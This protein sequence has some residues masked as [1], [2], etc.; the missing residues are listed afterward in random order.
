MQIRKNRVLKYVI[1]VLIFCIV[2]TIGNVFGQEILMK[3]NK[4]D[5][6]PPSPNSTALAKMI[7]IP[8]EE[9]TGTV[10]IDLPLYTIKNKEYEMPISL[11]Y[12]TNGIHVE[13]IS[14]WV[15]LGWSLN[16][17]GLVTRAVKGLPDDKYSTDDDD[18]GQGYLDSFNLFYVGENQK[19]ED[20]IFLLDQFGRGFYDSEPDMFYFKVPGYSGKF[21]F[22]NSEKIH[23]IPKQNIVIECQ[24]DAKKPIESF[25]LITP[26]GNK[27]FFKD[28]ESTVH[29]RSNKTTIFNSTW[30][31]SKVVT[32]D[33]E[34]S[35]KYVDEDYLERKISGEIARYDDGE[36]S[37]FFYGYSKGIRIHAKRLQEISWKDG[38]IVFDADHLRRD[39]TI[40]E[41]D[42]NNAYALSKIRIQNNEGKMV[43][44]YSFDYEYFDS[45]ADISENT[46]LY[47]RLKLVSFSQFDRNNKKH[48]PYKF[49][50]NDYE[51]PARVSLERDFWGFYNNNKAKSLI[52]NLYFYPDGTS[53]VYESQYSIFARSDMSNKEFFLE[54]N[55]DRNVNEVA[56]KA[57]VLEKMIYPTGGNVKIHYTPN[58]FIFNDRV[59]LGGG[60]R[61]SK[62]EYSMN[63]KVKKTK[64]YLYNENNSKCSEGLLFRI[65]HFAFQRPYLRSSKVDLE[66]LKE[67]TFYFSKSISELDAY[68]GNMV[69]YEYVTIKESENG[70]V[71]KKFDIPDI[72]KDKVLLKN[73]GTSHFEIPRYHSDTFGAAY[74]E[75]ENPTTKIGGMYRHFRFALGVYDNYPFAPLPDL[76]SYIGNLVEEHYYQQDNDK[77]PVKSIEYQYE[78]DDTNYINQAVVAFYEA[79]IYVTISHFDFT[80]TTRGIIHDYIRGRY[81]NLSGVKRLISKKEI[82]YS[83]LKNGKSIQKNVTYKY[84]SKNQLSCKI[85]QSSEGKELK[86]SY[87]YPVDYYFPPSKNIRQSCDVVSDVFRQMVENNMLEYPI[88]I[89]SYKD[90]KIIG[91]DLSLYKRIPGGKIKPSTHNKIELSSP[92]KPNIFGLSYVNASLD[93]LN[94]S[95]I[96]FTK[97][98]YY[99]KEIIYEKYDS[100]GNLVQYRKKDGIPVSLLW[101]SSGN[102]LIAKVEGCLYTQ[103]SFLNGMSYSSCKVLYDNIQAVVPK[104]KISTY[105]YEKLIGLSSQTDPNGITTY[106]EYDDFGR[107]KFVKDHESNITEK[108]NYNYALDKFKCSS[109]TSDISNYSL[110]N[111]ANF[112]ITPTGGSGDYSY[113][114]SFINGHSTLQ[115][116]TM[117]SFRVL[118]NTH[119]EM[120][121][122]CVVTDK[123]TGES[124]EKEILIR[125]KDYLVKFTNITQSSDGIH[126]KILCVKNSPITLELFSL[127][128]SGATFVVDGSNYH[129]SYYGSKIITVTPTK[130]LHVKI[131][132]VNSG[133]AKITIENVGK[134]LISSPSEL[135][136][137]PN[138]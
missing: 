38:K 60:L 24:R 136:L 19:Q 125:V 20:A 86:T 81:T 67:K 119:G 37:N 45:S 127:S 80:K 39:V 135:M 113:S 46:Y 43:K 72:R 36:F 54:N 42:D 84:N 114:W 40:D 122:K 130:D 78:F 102:Y 131:S 100:L 50:Y 115:R 21:V 66:E 1:T 98:K 108:I 76:S 79:S 25:T 31:L 9:F 69:V 112:D 48:S 26:D 14:T 120:K 107:L 97:S 95:L 103:I 57:G 34:I 32:A 124:I 105:S 87:K 132:G 51:L 61:V 129:I 106:Y 23:M 65:P 16:C 58:R 3:N 74:L 104:A 27:Y 91:S 7:D 22:D 6:I 92:M 68:N 13:Q 55:V 44:G 88:E 93:N 117:K 63:G 75:Y 89:T 96:S 17:G 10:A 15:G 101:D 5:L 111:S 85:E 59:I 28:I 73:K 12:R 4:I 134:G 138:R 64:E 62:F 99:E 30:H 110:G 128:G 47:R 109:I 35:F 133:Y 8:V 49:K 52:P 137:R 56:L 18:T 116:G 2:L 90:G 71:V 77:K 83:F 118:F 126:A 53:G 94:L 33:G 11:S 29:Q 82:D 70:Y 41:K 121:V 123:V